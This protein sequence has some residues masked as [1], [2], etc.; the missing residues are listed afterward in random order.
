M[1]ELT[2]LFGSLGLGASHELGGEP[3][4]LIC[5]SAFEYKPSRYRVP[6]EVAFFHRFWKWTGD[7]VR[8]SAPLHDDDDI[9]IQLIRHPNMASEDPLR[10]VRF[11][12]GS[13]APPPAFT[14]VTSADGFTRANQF[15]NFKCLCSSCGKGG[16]WFYEMNLFV[17]SRTTRSDHHTSTV[18]GV[19]A[20][21]STADDGAME[22]TK[23]PHWRFGADRWAASPAAAAAATPAEVTP[24]EVTPDSRPAAAPL[25]PALAAATPP[26]L[27]AAATIAP[28]H[29]T[30]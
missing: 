3:M 23:G 26:D 10:T 28:S 27:V 30:A 22:A 13:K 2:G 11:F 9:I 1:S 5:K 21:R 7:A 6:Q 24:A 19:I 15:C 17:A 4:P 18:H 12:Q 8:A 25:T 29:E 14:E 20:P 16:G